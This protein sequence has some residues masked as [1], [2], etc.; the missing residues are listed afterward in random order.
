M[1]YRFKIDKNRVIIDQ[2]INCG[3]CYAC[4]QGRGNVSPISQLKITPKGLDVRGSRLQNKKFQTV[5][6]LIRDNKLDLKGSISHTYNFLD[7]QQAFDLADQ[8]DPSVRKIV[9]TF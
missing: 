2:V 9:L 3:E 6:D 5:L 4:K 7:A 8:Q 1:E